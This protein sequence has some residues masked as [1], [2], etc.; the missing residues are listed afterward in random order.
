MWDVH[1]TSAGHASEF[2]CCDCNIF[3]KDIHALVAHM[4]S[5]AHRRPLKPKISQKR[6]K[7]SLTTS[8]NTECTTCRRK[9]PSVQSLQQ[10]NASV[11]HKPLGKLKCPIGTRCRESFTSPS[12]L[13]HHLESG[14]CS[15]GFDRDEVYRMVSSCDSGHTIHTQAISFATALS[16]RKESIWGEWETSSF[17]TD[18]VWSLLTPDLSQGSMEDTLE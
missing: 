10:H 4:E 14:K 7:A 8:T 6:E 11:K 18:S 9:F 17:E 3:F 16:S 1:R 12:A 2:K 5:R 13:V 15:S